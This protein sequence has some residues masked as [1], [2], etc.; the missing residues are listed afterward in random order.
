MN[1]RFDFSGAEQFL[2]YFNGHIPLEWVLE[3]PAYQAVVCHVQLFGKGLR[4]QDVENALAG[5]PSTFYGLTALA[6]NLP[7]ILT[8][9]EFLRQRQADWPY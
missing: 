6:D 7:H 4:D 5:K 9:L 2:N 3:H 1:I 8:S